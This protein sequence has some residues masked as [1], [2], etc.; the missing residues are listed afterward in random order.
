MSCA[1]RTAHLPTKPPLP[2]R[3][4]RSATRAEVYVP[5]YQRSNVRM[6]QP[7]NVPVYQR[8]YVHMW[9][10][11]NVPVCQRFTVR[12]RQPLNAPCELASFVVSR[13]DQRQRA[14]YS[15]TMRLGVDFGTT[16]TTVAIV[17]RGNYPLLAFDDVVG[18]S[19]E[20]FPSVIALDAGKLV[21]G[22]EA[23]AAAEHGA[24]ALRSIK[25]MLADPGVNLASEVPLGSQTFL[26]ID[27]LTGFLSAVNHLIERKP[28]EELEVAVGVPAQAFS[29]QRFVTLEAFRRAGFDVVAMLNEP[30]AAGYEY[31]HRHAK[32]VTARRTQVLVYDLG[33]GTFDAS[34]VSVAGNDHVVEGSSGDN[35]L[36]GD[37]FDELLADLGCEAAGLDR[38]ELSSTEWAQIVDQAQTAKESLNPQTRVIGLEVLSHD[39]VVPVADYYAKAMPLVERTFTEV[40]RLLDFEEFPPDLSGMYVVG[41]GSELPL[42]LRALRERYGRRVRRSPYSAGSTAI[43]LAIAA[44]NEAGYSLSDQVSRGFGVF[45]EW[46]GGQQ[47]SFDSI[48]APDMRMETQ[49]TRSYQAVHNVGCYRFA[50]YTA[51]DADGTPRGQ[52]MPLAEM[53]LAFSAELRGKDIAGIAVERIGYGP[54]IEERYSIDDCGIVTV[55]ICDTSD[56]YTIRQSLGQ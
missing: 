45:R 39:V 3:N 19:H 21:Y 34:L 11:L 17:D 44:D 20:Y 16:R 7:L 27:L 8:F 36:G 52:V 6:W 14:G 24:P 35:V 33:G 28:G 50:E 51:L 55:E 41:G 49:V 56:G 22:F 29:A 10:R 54:I 30:S 5:V 2:G 15:Q 38:T 18:D 13:F 4:E 1:K 25:R 26:L 40:D 37:D 42:I 9:Q 46:D 23:R 12:M 32:L 47:I 48:L 43:G 31:T 53:H